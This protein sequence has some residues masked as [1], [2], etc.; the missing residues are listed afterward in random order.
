MKMTITSNKQSVEITTE[1]PNDQ[2]MLAK[3]AVKLKGKSYI[4]PQQ[5][6][7]LALTVDIEDLLAL[8]AE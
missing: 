7:Q 2:V 4:F 3:L 6:K 8:L 1:T 5:D